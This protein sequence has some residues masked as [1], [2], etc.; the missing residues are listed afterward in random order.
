MKPIEV[1]GITKYYRENKAL[2]N[3]TFTMEPGKIYGLLGRNGAGKTTLLNLITNRIFPSSGEIRIGGES[4]HEND[5]ALGIIYYMTEKNLFPDSERIKN[6]F[7]WTRQFYPAFDMDYAGGLSDKFGLDIKKKVKSLSTG[8]AS[9]FKAITALASNS[10][11]LLFD[12]PI[13]GLD[14]NHRDMF[15]KELLASYA[16][17]PRTIIISTHLIEEVAPV[18]EEV[19]IIKEGKLVIKQPVEKLLAHAYTVSGEASKVDKY[20]QGKKHTGS[21][22][23]GSLKSAVVLEDIGLKDKALAKELG[24]KFSKTELQKLFISLTN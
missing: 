7:K 8:Y 23:I 14:A 1:K 11:I 9:I 12:E 19:I 21:E 20:T 18:L 10:D 16:D 13:L 4:V 2:D 5:S 15:Y 3:V 24:L 22:T 17:K 6:I